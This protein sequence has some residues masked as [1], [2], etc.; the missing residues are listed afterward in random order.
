M[1]NWWHIKITEINSI[2]S[3]RLTWAW[4]SRPG[5]GNGICP[6][7]KKVCPRC[8]WH[9]AGGTPEITTGW[10]SGRWNIVVWCSALPVGGRH[11]VNATIFK[12]EFNLHFT[13]LNFYCRENMKLFHK[14]KK[15]QQYWFVLILCLF[16]IMTNYEFMNNQSTGRYLGNSKGCLF[17]PC[18]CSWSRKKF[19][20]LTVN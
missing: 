12:Q 1:S 4:R 2:Q 15:T 17:F 9:L 8:G 11:T 10:A 16:I 5:W 14:W 18:T 20:I 3:E 6:G 13:F 19:N 7:Q